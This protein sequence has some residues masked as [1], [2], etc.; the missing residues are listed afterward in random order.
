MLEEDVMKAR[1]LIVAAISI[2]LVLLGSGAAEAALRL[3]PNW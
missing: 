2:A 1:K 3:R